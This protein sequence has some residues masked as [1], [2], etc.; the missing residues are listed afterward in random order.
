MTASGDRWRPQVP[1]LVVIT[2]PTSSPHTRTSRRTGFTLIDVLVSMAI[3]TVLISL[4]A[5]SLSTVRESARQVICRSNVRQCGISIQQYAD[6]NFDFVPR[7]LVDQQAHPW[8]SI[9]LR[10]GASS[11]SATPPGHQGEWDGLGMLYNKEFLP[12]PKIFYCPSH[13]GLNPFIAYADQ[14]A[15]GDGAIV[16]NYQYRGGGPPAGSRPPSPGQAPVIT[17]VL[18]SI[19]PSAALVADGMRVQAD[20]NHIVGSTVL[21]AD[22]SVVWF[23]DSNR[24]VLNLLPKDTAQ[25]VNAQNFAQAWNMLDNPAK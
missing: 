13:K 5:P 24:D 3:I 25:T 18:P 7:S 12:A 1:D 14:W 2:K 11:S 10:Y 8:D 19:V 16:G 4:L 6:Q 9:Y 15:G 17:Q 20:F 22:L 23:P 21:R